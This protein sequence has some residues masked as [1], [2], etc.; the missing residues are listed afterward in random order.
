[1]GQLDAPV[2]DL[3]IRTMAILETIDTLRR[4]G[5]RDVYEVT[6]L[7]NSFLGALAHPS[8]QWEEAFQKRTGRAERF[9]GW[10]TL[11]TD[12]ERDDELAHPGEA[13]K[14]LRNAMAHGN[15][16]FLSDAEGDIAKVRLWNLTPDGYWDWGTTLTVRELRE[17]LER[18][19]AIA[20][21]LPEHQRGDPPHV[22][23]RPPQTP[24][25]TCGQYSRSRRPHR[26]SDG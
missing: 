13:L 11:S 24:C 20:T 17:I 9:A 7:V 6:Q 3:M 21:R 5:Q 22:R 25:Q 10:P 4:Q 8:E 1:M 12:D 19:V 16:K 15:V 18:V 2:R 26:P 23:D 14:K